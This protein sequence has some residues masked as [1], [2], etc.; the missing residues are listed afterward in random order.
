MTAPFFKR[1]YKQPPILFPLAALFLIAMTLIAAVTLYPTPLLQRDWLR[2]L[3]MLLYSLC[4]LF[5]CDMKKWAAAGFIVMTVICL[6][7][8]YFAPADSAGRIF[9][10]G[11]FPL[12]MV[13]SFFVLL[14]FKRFH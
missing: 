6:A 14:Y 4:W 5:V 2:P 12:D 9:A 1:I 7:L 11:L 8:Q 3:A 13:L 10:S